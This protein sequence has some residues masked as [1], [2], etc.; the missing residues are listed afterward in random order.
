MKK[1][2]LKKFLLLILLINILTACAGLNP[3][4]K[5][6]SPLRV[7]F[8]QWWGDYTLLVAQEKGLFEKYGVEVEP[9]YYDVFSDT[10][11]DLAAGQI[12]GALIAVGDTI[13][14]NR[15]S[16][17]KVVA[18]YD[19]GGNDAVIVGPEINSIQD[20]R[21]KTVGTLTGS[22][23]ELT[24]VDMLRSGN[25]SIDDITMIALNPEDSLASLESGKVQA[26]YTWEPYLSEALEKGYKV[27][28]PEKQLHL[29]PDLIVFSKSVVDERPEDV[30][31][32]LKAWFQAVEYRLQHEGETRDIAAKYLGTNSSNI[33][34]DANLKLLTN[35]DNKTMFNIKEKSSIYSITN[36]TSDY[37]IGI[38]VI[39]SQIDPLQLLDPSYL[40]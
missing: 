7:E 18:V 3:S 5:V 26:A 17:M 39:T 12:D 32:F 10:Y 31:A 6:K 38:G 2:F 16:P 37:L 20:L 22:Q 23:Y 35:K 29:Y 27:I 36:T 40:P 19:D 30:R 15:N 24:V 8:T 33:R 14:I 28:Y 9:V 21:G 11:P 25:M 34:P 4:Q 13:N 1:S